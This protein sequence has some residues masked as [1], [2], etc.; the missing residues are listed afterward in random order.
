MIQKDIRYKMLTSFFLRAS[1]FLLFYFVANFPLF[2][3]LAIPF[4][5][6]KK[7][8]HWFSSSKIII[9]VLYI[10]IDVLVFCI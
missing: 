5:N 1:I 9:L 8:I 4:Q 3:K 10:G 7:H 2:L 6:H